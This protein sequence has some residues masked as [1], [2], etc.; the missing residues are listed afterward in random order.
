MQWLLV[1]ATDTPRNVQPQDDI[2]DFCTSKGILMEA[3]SPLGSNDSP[4]CVLRITMPV[5]WSSADFTFPPLQ[6][7]RRRRPQDCGKARR[8]E[9]DDPDLLPGRAQRRCPA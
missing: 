8:R 3:Y 1:A 4:M 7:E 5:V 6:P 9:R 2:V